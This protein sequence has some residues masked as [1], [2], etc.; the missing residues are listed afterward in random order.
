MDKQRALGKLKGL[1]NNVFWPAA[2]G[3]VFWSFWTV[4]IQGSLCKNW[5]TL[6]FLILLASYLSLE[7]LIA[8]DDADPPLFR[9]VIFD[10]AYLWAVSISAV[11]AAGPPSRYLLGGLL[12]AFVIAGIGYPAGAFPDK[13]MDKKACGRWLSG[14]ANIVG[15]ALL[16][17]LWCAGLRYSLVAA[18]SFTAVLVACVFIQWK[19]RFHPIWSALRS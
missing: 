17:W 5:P 9:V 12:A 15:A 2:A 4:L 19:P 11:A 7:W 3:N 1:S 13:E 8:K 10:I 6:V 14:A 18:M 16:V